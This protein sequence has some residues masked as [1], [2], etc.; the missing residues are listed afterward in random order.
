MIARAGKCISGRA[1]RMAVIILV[2]SQ[3]SHNEY[4]GD[5]VFFE[6]GSG[7]DVD[8]DL[9]QFLAVDEECIVCFVGRIW[10]LAGSRFLHFGYGAAL[11]VA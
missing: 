9:S 11:V 6:V 4:I 10:F 8:V 2:I 1:K 7:A 3:I 5:G